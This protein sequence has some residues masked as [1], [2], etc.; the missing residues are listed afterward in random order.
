MLKFFDR[1]MKWI[2]EPGEFVVMIG[3]SSDDKDLKMAS[4]SLK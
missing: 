2:L 1:K 3:K 4:F